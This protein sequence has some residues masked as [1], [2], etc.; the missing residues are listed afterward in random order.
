MNIFVHANVSVPPWIDACLRRFLITPDMHRIHHSEE[1]MEQNSNFGVVF[2]WWDRLFGTYRPQPAAGHDNM[3]VGLREIGVKQGVSLTGMLALPFRSASKIT[4][5][6][7]AP[8]PNRA[9]A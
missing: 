1:L 2:P 6:A 5:A 9:G 3:G 7:C 8:T 4:P